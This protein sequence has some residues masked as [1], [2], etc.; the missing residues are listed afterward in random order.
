MKMI[1]T[2]T[3]HWFAFRTFWNS[4]KNFIEFLKR[5]GI[6]TYLPER[7]I[8]TPLGTSS[9]LVFPT[10]VFARMTPILAKQIQCDSSLKASPYKIVGTTA[11]APISDQEMETFIWVTKTGCRSLEAYRVELVKGD[12]VRVIDGIFKGA[13]GYVCRIRGTKRFVV[14]INGVAAVA[15]T[16]IPRGFLE[17]ITDTTRKKI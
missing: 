5:N 12:R 14:K 4:Q 10:L 2:T 8:D 13:E 11:P 16:Y 7:I 1:D 17:K 15:T 6:Q 9:E 3:M